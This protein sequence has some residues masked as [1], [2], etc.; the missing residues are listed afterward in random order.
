LIN[1]GFGSS[2]SYNVVASSDVRGTIFYDYNN[3]GYYADPNGFSQFSSG[4]FNS[5]FTQLGGTGYYRDMRFRDSGGG[6]NTDPYSL[7]WNTP[8]YNSSYLAFNIND[9]SDEELR[10]YGYS[11]SGYGCGEFSGN[12]PFRFRADGWG[13]ASSYFEGGGSLRA[14]VFYDSNDTGY[15]ADFNYPYTDAVVIRGGTRHGPNPSWGAYL[16]VGNDGR[17]DGWASVVTT[18]GNLHLDCRNGYGLYL[19]HY[20]GNVS[21]AYDFRPTIIYDQNNTGYYWDG[22][23]DSRMLEVYANSW[24]RNDGGGG[25]YFQSYGRGLRATDAQGS[26]YGNVSTYGGGRNGWYGWAI[27]TTHVFMSTLGD[28]MGVHDNRYGWIYLWD[29]GAFNVYRGYTYSVGSMRSP[30]FYDSDNTAYYFGGEG[31]NSLLRV[32]YVADINGGQSY[33]GGQYM[34]ESTRG[35]YNHYTNSPPLQAFS[36]SGNAA[37]MS[38]HRSSHYA[39]N[40]G[41]DGDNNFR[42]GGWSAQAWFVTFDMY[43]NIFERGYIYQGYSD[44]RMKDILGTIPDALGKIN[45]LNGFYYRTNA[46]AKSF[47]YDDD[48]K[49]Q[50]GVSAQE[51][52]KVLPEIVSIAPFDI[53]F[54]DPDDHSIITSKSGENYLTVSYERLAPLFIEGIKEISTEIEELKTKVAQLRIEID[55]LKINR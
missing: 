29:G 26:P 10:I 43:G 52:Q 8:G 49:L 6:A 35:Y 47:G 25:L 1:G 11:C 23:G 42:W 34:F 28:N 41:L 48:F 14:P 38:F 31:S 15:Y 16:R 21:Y 24:F 45:S 50:V 55:E 32:S 33:D 7:V 2:M 20:T 39:I 44:A 51:V 30:L 46:L 36:Y 18:N 17:Q 27:D 40:M 5:T 3:T 37:F 54:P 22:N 9:D 19:N 53:N 13:Y 4:N 12:L